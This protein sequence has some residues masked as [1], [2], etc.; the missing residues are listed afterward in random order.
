MFFGTGTAAGYRRVV[1]LAGGIEAW[2]ASGF[3]VEPVGGC[4]P[5]EPSLLDRTYRLDPP[6]RM[7]TWAGRNLN[8][9]HDGIIPLVDGQIAIAGGRLEGGREGGREVRSSST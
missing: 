5:V 8:G 9:R 2:E 4:Y 6:H 7:V 3:G 1:T